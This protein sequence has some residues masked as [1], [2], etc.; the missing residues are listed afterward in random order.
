MNSGWQKNLNNMDIKEV[1]LDSQPALAIKDVC[2]PE[3]LG[4]KFGEV[5]GEI[6]AY[7]KKNSI[8]SAGGP[9]GIYHSFSPEKVDLE[10]GIPVDGE[11][12]GEGRIYRMYT[13]CGKAVMTVFTGHYD[14]LK[15]AWGEFAKAVDA[16]G[17][18]LN[19]PCF[20]VYITDPAEEPDSSK[21]VTELYTP[22]V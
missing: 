2:T 13:Y 18:Q 12:Q 19:G 6:D 7:L 3:K 1:E 21:W 9:F 15:Q 4:D 17:Y 10:A 8:Q 20:E 5:Y 14:G 22:I 16:K 11:S